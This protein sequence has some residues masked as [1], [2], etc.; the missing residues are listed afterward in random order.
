D[1][2][3]LLEGLWLH[4]CPQLEGPRNHLSDGRLTTHTLRYVKVITLRAKGTHFDG[5]SY[6]LSPDSGTAINSVVGG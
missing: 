5:P 6:G 4:C 3:S 1:G 2:S